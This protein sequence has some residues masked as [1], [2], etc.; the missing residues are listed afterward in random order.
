MNSSQKIYWPFVIVLISIL[1]GTGL[2]VFFG[3]GEEKIKKQLELNLSKNEKLDQL[4]EDQQK[5]EKDKLKTK[6]WSYIQRAHLHGGGI[7]ALTLGLLFLLERISISFSFKNLIGVLLSTGGFLYPFFWL[8]SGFHA[9]ELGTNAAK[10]KF[11]F[12]AYGGAIHVAMTFLILLLW[13]IR[14]KLSSENE[15]VSP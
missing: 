3:V 12:L 4:S 9:P 15:S 13:I 8:L 10:D 2:G 6:A 5:I 1:F 11:E 14:P 7:A